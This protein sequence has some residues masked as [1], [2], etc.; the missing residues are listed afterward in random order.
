MKS[1]L[2]MFMT[3]VLTGVTAACAPAPTA[4]ALPT[5][6]LIP[7]APTSAA[8]PTSTVADLT[9]VSDGRERSYH[10]FRPG[11]L[12]ANS[13]TPLVV[14]LHYSGGTG[15]SV[16]PDTGL[17]AE[18]ERTRFIAVYPDAIGSQWNA[19]IC[20]GTAVSE[21]VDD[22]AFINRLI[23]RLS[24]ENRVDSN[25]IY[26]WGISNGGMM[27]YRVG[28][29]LSER[30]AAIASSAGP[31]VLERCQPVRPVSVVHFHS[32]ADERSPFKGGMRPGPPVFVSLAIPTI[33]ERWRELDG[34][35]ASPVIE[36]MGAV[37]K[38]SSKGCR[39]GTEVTL[40]T[41]EQGSHALPLDV[42]SRNITRL[43]LDFFAAHSKSP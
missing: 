40:Y 18:A 9:L 27:A 37:T 36:Q 41:A 20:C 38:T 4:S 39:E 42:A 12:D 7:V 15:R 23:D 26:V 28:C 1:T 33:I 32:I 34:C 17:E 5:S 21:G 16:A 11:N 22:V 2:S 29:E 19:G 14:F 3:I 30:I 10:L 8:T 6:T 43:V 13:P 31:L 35:S 25:R 24:S